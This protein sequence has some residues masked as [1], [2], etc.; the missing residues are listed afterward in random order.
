MSLAVY[1]K[2]R[3]VIGLDDVDLEVVSL[4]TL[5]MVGS[6][7]TLVVARDGQPYHISADQANTCIFLASV[8]QVNTLYFA[9]C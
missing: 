4:G 6:S 7:A 8:D 1:L 9:L 5:R 3:F 2:Q